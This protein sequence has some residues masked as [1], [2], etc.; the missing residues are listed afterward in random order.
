MLYIYPLGNDHVITANLQ[1]DE[2]GHGSVNIIIPCGGSEPP[3]TYTHDGSTVV[4]NVNEFY[5]AVNQKQSNNNDSYCCNAMGGT[6]CYQLNITCMLAC[7]H[8][9]IFYSVFGLY[10]HR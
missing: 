1:V 3:Y 5:T 10:L 7:M 8:A 6:T 9:C 4:E 2:H